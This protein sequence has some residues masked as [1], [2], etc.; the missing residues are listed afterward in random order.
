VPAH[1]VAS[2]KE[3]LDPLGLVGRKIGGSEM[4]PLVGQ[5]LTTRSARK[6]TNSWL[7]LSATGS[8][9][10]GAPLVVKRDVL[11][12][13]ALATY[14]EPWHFNR[15]GRGR[16]HRIEAIQCRDGGLLIRSRRVQL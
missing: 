2:P 13:D 3:L 11:R 7:R 10:P 6:A 4:K 14:L 9:T 12:K 16:S 15:S 5:P 1:L 8:P